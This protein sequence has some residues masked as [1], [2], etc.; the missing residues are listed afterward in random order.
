MALGEGSV[1][2]MTSSSLEPRP[3]LLKKLQEAAETAKG[4][5]GFGRGVD[6]DWF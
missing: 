6:L 5:Y 1:K 4:R 3:I 2:G